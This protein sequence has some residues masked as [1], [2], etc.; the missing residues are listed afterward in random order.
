[1]SLFLLP[2]YAI[3]PSLSFVGGSI[4]TPEAGLS[5]LGAFGAFGVGALG[6]VRSSNLPKS[7]SL[8]KS[9]T[10]ALSFIAFTSALLN[11][12][13][14]FSSPPINQFPVMLALVLYL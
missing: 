14:T 2:V 1:M 8:G 12:L 13:F 7:D 9:A 11:I 4:L 5:G 6:L 10:P 3:I